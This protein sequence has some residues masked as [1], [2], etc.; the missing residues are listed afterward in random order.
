MS[1]NVSVVLSQRE[2][3]L[4]VPSEAVF[5][6]GGQNFVFIVKADSSVTRSPLTLG[7]RLSDVVEVL[8]GLK[9]GQQVVRAGHQK[10]FEGAKV[11]PVQSG[12]GTG[13]P[14]APEAAKSGGAS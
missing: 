5:S 3:A 1:A 2:K 14:G 10:L 9:A 8:T 6:E 7:T 13:A 4:T 12:A 11:I